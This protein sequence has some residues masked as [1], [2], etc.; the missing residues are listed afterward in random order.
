MIA[1]AGLVD[2][3]FL[4]RLL[5]TLQDT[6]WLCGLTN[7]C[8]IEEAS[9]IQPGAK[10]I[11]YCT[12]QIKFAEKVGLVVKIKFRKN[13]YELQLQFRQTNETTWYCSKRNGVVVY[14]LKDL[15]YFIPEKNTRFA[16][17]FQPGYLE[18]AGIR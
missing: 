5:M 7:I 17:A 18:A 10:N 2:N 8:V 1:V 12:N 6:Y 9:R 13:G 16:Q 4:Q 14:V 15:L 11:K 3:I